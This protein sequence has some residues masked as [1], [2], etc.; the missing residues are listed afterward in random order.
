MAGSS[1]ESS[2]EFAVELAAQTTSNE[3]A[4]LRFVAVPNEPWRP[5]QEL[6]SRILDE[7]RIVSRIAIAAT[8]LNV[9][10]IAWV[11]RS[12]TAVRQPIDYEP[13]KGTLTAALSPVPAISDVRV[14]AKQFAEKL[15]SQMEHR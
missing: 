2:A 13:V 12:E 8:L 3:A 10:H 4:L 9:N 5:S 1:I 14:R 7:A 11:T 6:V 15:L